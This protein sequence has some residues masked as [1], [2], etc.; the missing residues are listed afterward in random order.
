MS[1]TVTIKTYYR[2]LQGEWNLSRTRRVQRAKAQEV[3]DSIEM[4]LGWKV[5]MKLGD[6]SIKSR[7]I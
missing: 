2:G 6:G 5:E 4:G 1:K 7:R 3:F